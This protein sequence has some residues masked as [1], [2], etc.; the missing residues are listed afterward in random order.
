MIIGTLKNCIV[1]TTVSSLRAAVAKAQ[2]RTIDARKLDRLLA[3]PGP[4]GALSALGPDLGPSAQLQLSDVAD[5]LEVFENFAEWHAPRA[6]LLA[7]VF[8]SSVFLVAAVCDRELCVRLVF[9]LAGALFF[10]AWPIA[11]RYPRYRHLVSPVKWAFWGVPTHIEWAF[12]ELRTNRER[13][14][15][16]RL[17][18]EE[19]DHGGGK[20]NSGSN[21]A[22]ARP[23]GAENITAYSCYYANHYGSLVVSP[24][25]VRFEGGG[26]WHT[27]RRVL[28]DKRWKDLVEIAKIGEG[29]TSKRVGGAQ[30][31]KMV[32]LP[33]PAAPAAG[34]GAGGMGMGEEAEEPVVLARMGRRRDEAFSAVVEF[35]GQNWQW[36]G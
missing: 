36:C 32:F 35:S 25:G 7:L 31:L 4:A 14:I 13:L 1:P 21:E 27:E 28:W 9:L 26:G 30:G 11:S 2:S 10:G 29:S 19:E 22:S 8:L 16:R 6:T 20:E 3:H 17:D 24:G 5:M 18:G 34:F 33:A 15:S 23:A 12:A